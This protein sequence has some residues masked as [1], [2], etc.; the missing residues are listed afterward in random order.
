MSIA[1]KEFFERLLQA[2]DIT[3]QMDLARALDLNR[4][5]I[6]QAKLRNAVP[7]KWILALARRYS[8]SPDWLEFGTGSP[9]PAP[10]ALKQPSDTPGQRKTV[11]PAKGR[12]HADT[13]LGAQ[14]A[15]PHQA[16]ASQGELHQHNVLFVPKA[17]ARLCAGGGSYEVDAEPVG[18]YALPRPWLASLGNP[19]G[20][21]LMDVVGDSMEPGICHGDTVLVDRSNQRL[22]PSAI[23]AVGVED[24]IYLKRIEQHNRGL[25]LL[26]D[27]PSYSPLELHGDELDTFRIIGKMVWLCREY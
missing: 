10:L 3:S 18:H 9:R 7:Q 2:T 4:S 27:N 17:A 20:M 11:G 22:H 23:M 6:T 19:A 8:L 13:R 26:S 25:V 12:A 24:A 16:H 1:F 5:A 15:F 21:V 14:N